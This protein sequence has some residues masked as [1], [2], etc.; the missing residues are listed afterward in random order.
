M[1]I[2]FI[3]TSVGVEG[4]DFRD[5]ESC[6]IADTSMDFGKALTQLMDDES[7]RERLVSHASN[8]FVNKYS[9]Q[10]L[11]NVRNSVYLSLVD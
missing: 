2:P 4:L 10:A 9:V 1:N 7:L 5:G 6:L 3:T 11:A 8:V